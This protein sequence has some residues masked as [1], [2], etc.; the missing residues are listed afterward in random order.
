[1]VSFQVPALK[2]LRWHPQNHFSEYRLKWQVL[3]SQK[4]VDELKSD[5]KTKWPKS[6]SYKKN[7]YFVGCVTLYSKSAGILLMLLICCAP[8]QVCIP[9]PAPYFIIIK[10]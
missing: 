3:H 8:V 2:N 6:N 9:I 1:M 10:D 5:E 7:L 4:N